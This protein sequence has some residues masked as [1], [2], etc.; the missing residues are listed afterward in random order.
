MADKVEYLTAF[1]TVPQ[2][3]ED[4]TR[5][6]KFYEH[7]RDGKL[8]TTK[9]NSCGKILWPPRI[10]CNVCISDDLEWIDMPETGKIYSYTVQVA[11]LPLGVDPPVVYAL[12]D[13]P[14]GVRV[15]SRLVDVKPEETKIGLE[16]ELAARETT[17][18]FQGR[19]RLVPYL[20]LKR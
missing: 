6:Y 7:L 4:S 11:G 18:D 13:F 1:D 2:Q 17:P 20:T 3:Y 5:L 16:V 12:V 19:T 8:T 15:Y 9:C 14:N 10:I